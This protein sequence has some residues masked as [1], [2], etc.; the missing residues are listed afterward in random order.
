MNLC[1]THTAFLLT[2]HITPNECSF[3]FLVNNAD[4]GLFSL[5]FICIRSNSWV[6]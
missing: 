3:V 6:K 5:C 4:F 2:F 1:R